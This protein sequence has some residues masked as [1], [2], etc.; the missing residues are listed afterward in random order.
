V[1]LRESAR[2]VFDAALSAGD[3]RPL[4]HRSLAGLPTHRRVLVVG[5]GKASGAMAA[6]AEEVLG[7]RIAGGVVAVK[8]GHLAPTRRVRLLE[9]GHP[10]PDERGAAAARAIHDLV[11][12]AEADDLVLVL[13]SGGG[14][15]LT[16]APAPPITLAEKQALTRLMLRAGAT[17]NELNAVRKHCSL[18]KGGQLARAAAPAR[19]HSL[20]LSDVIGDPLDVIASGP[21][22]PDES[23]YDEALA[24]LVRF[25]IADQVAP[26]IRRRLE[27]GR[28]G[29]IPETPK[30]GDP[31]F[32]RVTNTVIGNNHLVIEA[33]LRRARALGFA[34]HLV[35]RTLEGEARE[36]A[37]RFVSMAR[38]V[39]AGTGPLQPPCCLVA[40]GE[41]TVKVTGQG[42][43]GRC[44]EFALAAAIAMAGMPGV[45]VLAAGT[46]GS[47]GPTTAAGAIVDGESAARARALA[48]DLAAR[49]TD[50]D[51]NP[52][53][54]ALGDLIVTGPSNTN[55]LDLYLVL[56]GP[57]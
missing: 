16:P 43:G 52:A 35:T 45:V 25:G 13:I 34:P 51:A 42:S 56:V 24:I 10:V 11:G 55:L 49:L 21:T 30:P 6:A 47:D 50:N 18:L 39:R 29:E 19:V 9:A 32:A 4:V 53:L 5:A 37:G 2:A 46:D 54:A 3:V 27:Q 48:V 33:A 8:D 15:A 7:D 14:S 23:T 31:L 40:G 12:S 22:A 57:P 36:L 28:R 20:L 44:Q 1:T 41:T 26:S 17:I 38:D